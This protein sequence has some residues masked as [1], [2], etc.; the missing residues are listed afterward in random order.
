MFPIF[1]N[2]YNNYVWKYH[3]LGA[4]DKTLLI[5]IISALYSIYIFI[6]TDNK[7][8]N[9]VISNYILIILLYFVIYNINICN[10]EI[11]LYIFMTNINDIIPF[12]NYIISKL[13]EL[14]EFIILI[15]KT[16]FIL[17]YLV[18][19]YI[20]YYKLN[21]IEIIINDNI[22]YSSFNN[23]KRYYTTNSK[24][25]SFIKDPR[26]Q[27]HKD[28]FNDYSELTGEYMDTN[29]KSLKY[30]TLRYNS[31]DIHCYKQITDYQYPGT[32]IHA[33]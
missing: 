9:C 33:G 19:M 1:N 31:T 3:T 22:Y 21:N 13:L 10:I 24:Y 11:I 18:Y 8:L 25:N 28:V 32:S 26:F 12:A 4:R 5:L 2:I 7:G 27:K 23:Q 6:Y 17:I 16:I 14:L 29:Y 30:P 15:L 20:S